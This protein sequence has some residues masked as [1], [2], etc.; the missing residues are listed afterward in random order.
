MAATVMFSKKTRTKWWLAKARFH[1][2]CKHKAAASQCL[3]QA[4]NESLDDTSALPSLMSAFLAIRTDAENTVRLQSDLQQLQDSAK[5]RNRDA[6]T[7]YRTAVLFAEMQEF[8]LAVNAYEH[9]LQSSPHWSDVYCNLGLAYGQLG[10]RDNE[11]ACYLKA[12]DIEPQHGNAWRNLAA[13]YAECGDYEAAIPCWRR[14]VT[15]QERDASVWVSLGWALS[16]V[17]R[18]GDA[19]EAYK[20]AVSRKPDFAVGYLNVALFEL[21]QGHRDAAIKAA[22]RALELD[23][24]YA[25]A[26]TVMGMAHAE[27]GNH[28][29]ALA[30]FDSAIHNSPFSLEPYVNKAASL[31]ELNR[32]GDARSVLKKA[33]ELQ[34]KSA[35][36][37]Y[38]IGE[39][40]AKLG[41]K[42]V[43][44]ELRDQLNTMG[45]LLAAKLDAVIAP[46]PAMQR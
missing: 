27:G 31:A 41:D 29:L 43:A 38:A 18:F 20:E 46:K 9:A 32:V 30:A 2:W 37:I 1:V 44:T 6:E 36:A 25:D 11:Q 40:Y 23:P 8:R 7:Y 34:P 13:C 39:T 14:V 10:E 19:V 5:D 33:L 12:I 22:Q 45:S 28:E 21:K 26:L 3:R 35:D 16:K 42:E 4:L 15:L 24:G 17:E